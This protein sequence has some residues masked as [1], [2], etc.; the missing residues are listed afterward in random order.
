MRA[1]DCESLTVTQRAQ[2][3]NTKAIK[4]IYAII[5]KMTLKLDRC[6]KN[7]HQLK[8]ETAEHFETM[9]VRHA[10]CVRMRLCTG[11]PCIYTLFAS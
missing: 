8:A 6:D 4:N 7:L 5:S 10:A 1:S 9:E 11:S 3:A 2:A